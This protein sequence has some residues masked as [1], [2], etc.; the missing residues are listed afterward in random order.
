MCILEIKQM[1]RQCDAVRRLNRKH[2]G[3]AEAI[4]LELAD[5]LRHGRISRV[6]NT[7]NWSDDTYARALYQHCVRNGLYGC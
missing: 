1:E 4:I 3:N 7:H 2:A 6:S 5:G